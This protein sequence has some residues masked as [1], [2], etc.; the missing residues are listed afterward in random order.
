MFL[1]KYLNIVH[2]SSYKSMVD[3]VFLLPFNRFWVDGVRSALL[4][5]SWQFTSIKFTFY[6]QLPVQVIEPRKKKENC[7][8]ILV[9]FKS[10]TELKQ[11][12]LIQQIKFRCAYSNSVWIFLNKQTTHEGLYLISKKESMTDYEIW[13]K[14]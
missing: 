12:R 11:K 4:H 1:I 9:M 7:R 8:R 13:T 2:I 14:T 6:G 3:W 5:C 10:Q